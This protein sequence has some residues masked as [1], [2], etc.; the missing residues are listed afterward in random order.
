MPRHGF[1]PHSWP[2]VWV[3]KTKSA[4]FSA[5]TSLHACEFPSA[6]LSFALLQPSSDCFC[7]DD[8]V[9]GF[10]VS[11]VL[12]GV[13]WSTLACVVVGVGEGSPTSSLLAGKL[14]SPPALSA[15]APKPS[16]FPVSPLSAAALSKPVSSSSASRCTSRRV[17]ATIT[18]M[19]TTHRLCPGVWVTAKRRHSA[20]LSCSASS[21]DPRSSADTDSSSGITPSNLALVPHPRRSNGAH[22]GSSATVSAAQSTRAAAHCAGVLVPYWNSIAAA[23]VTGVSTVWF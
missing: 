22:A 10:S 20:S 16:P 1:G 2:R 13:V 14:G 18:A 12:L 15:A 11:V 21:P 5:H 17:S 4:P 9:L 7:G 23:A 8:D 6:S 19:P 3:S